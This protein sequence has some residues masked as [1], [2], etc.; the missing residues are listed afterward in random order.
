MPSLGVLPLLLL[1]LATFSAHGQ[2]EAAKLVSSYGEAR[3]Q[4]IKQVNQQYIQQC[5]K[6]FPLSAQTPEAQR[7]RIWIGQLVDGAEHNDVGG[8]A[9]SAGSSSDRL[10]TLQTQYLKDRAAALERENTLYIAR[11]E[12]FQRQTKTAV[13]SA[14]ADTV[15]GL[16][17]KLVKQGKWQWEG[18]TLIGSGDSRTMGNIGIDNVG[19]GNKFGPHGGDEQ[20]FFE[21]TH[22]RTYRCT[23]VVNRKKSEL[24]VDGEY[25]TDGNAQEG[26]V[27]AIVLNAGDGWSPGTVEWRDLVI[28]IGTD[29]VAFP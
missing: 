21:F 9:P 17:A 12:S 18:T 16:L 2:V 10:T 23:L 26:K 4:A 8:I 28:L 3:S 5:E 7:A 20:K 19:Y 22:G 6:L 14:A 11:L 25:V 1:F 27:E 24:Y 15:S 29:K 13:D